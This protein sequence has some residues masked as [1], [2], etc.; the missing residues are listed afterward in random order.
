MGLTNDG[1]QWIASALADSEARLTAQLTGLVDKEWTQAQLLGLADK[2]WTLSRLAINAAAANA[3]IERTET[4]LLTEFHKWASP[5]EQRLRTHREALRALDLEVVNLAD[6]VT[7]LEPRNNHAP[8]FS[9]LRHFP[10]PRY[11]AKSVI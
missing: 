3:A 11:P 4:S 7:K 9:F 1:K 10:P 5:V 8:G 2:E 6:R